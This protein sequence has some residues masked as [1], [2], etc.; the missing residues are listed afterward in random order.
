MGILSKPSGDLCT[1]RGRERV[2]RARPH[3]PAAR[4]AAAEAGG[5]TAAGHHRRWVWVAKCRSFLP[6]SPLPTL[7]RVGF[8]SSPMAVPLPFHSTPG[9][10]IT[11]HFVLAF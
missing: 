6:K 2:R 5:G 8:A 4:A 3:V 10:R 1:Q 11:V 9:V 7:S